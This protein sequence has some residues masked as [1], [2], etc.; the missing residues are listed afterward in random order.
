MTADAP[1]AATNRQVVIAR[2]RLVFWWLTVA[3]SGLLTILYMI[4]DRYAWSELFTI[5]PANLWLFGLVPL[6]LLG[7]DRK[8]W[9]HSLAAWG[10]VLLFLAVGE[11]W[12]SLLRFG[13]VRATQ[14]AQ[15]IRIVSWNVDDC[16]GGSADMF[17][18]LAR[19]EPDIC[20]M[21]E[22]PDGADWVSK[23]RLGEYFRDFHFEDAGDCAVLSRWPLEKLQTAR[24]GPWGDPQVLVA[25]LPDGRRLLLVDVRLMHPALLVNPL[26]SRGR[27]D[28]VARH[29]DRAEQFRK[30]TDLVAS[31]HA[32]AN[33]DAAILAGD[34]NSPGQSKLAAPLCRELHDAWKVA[35]RGWGATILTSFPVARI[36]QCWVSDGIRVLDARVGKGAAS[37]HRPVVVELELASE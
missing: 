25:Q 27:A 30:L 31:R 14:H 36:D 11:E 15:Q 34:F 35:G 16:P 37:D 29:S 33:C 4:G 19:F 2:V 18:H 26:T 7:T 21:Q 32:D 28:L 24:V 12:R 3:C 6:A 8:R 13:A 1:A 22:T 5:W 23:E 10:S 20:F 9:R 17:Q